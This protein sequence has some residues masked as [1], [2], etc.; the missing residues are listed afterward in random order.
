VWD[1]MRPDFVSERYAPT[2]WKLAQE[3]V[4][5]SH[6]HSVYPTA[7]YVNGAALATGVYPNR[8]NLLAN[9][10]YQPLINP[11]TFFENGEMP[12]IKKGD[13]V[14][15]G[16]Y[17]AA[18]TI[19]EIVRG[20]G[21][22]SVIAGTKSVVLLHDRHAEWTTAAMNAL[23]KFAAAPMPPNLRDETLRLLGPFLTAPANTNDQRN[24]YATRALTEILWRDGIPDFSL[25]WLNEPD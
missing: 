21:R 11:H 4:N 10:E 14:T 6:H 9:R 1:G 8:N 23:T 7:T 12:I 3:G 20:A 24:T 19:A 18:P 22:R 15:G 5:F 16:K 17:L 25:L 2:L 13:E